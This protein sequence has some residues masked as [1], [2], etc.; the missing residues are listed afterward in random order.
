MAVVTTASD[1]L[2]PKSAGA[3]VCFCRYQ[4][5]FM[6][7]NRP[8][9]RAMLRVPTTRVPRGSLFQRVQAG[10][11]FVFAIC[12]MNREIVTQREVGE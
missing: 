8:S 10:E 2:A 6:N 4:P 1:G 5:T 9:V 7:A 12:D 11:S 3:R